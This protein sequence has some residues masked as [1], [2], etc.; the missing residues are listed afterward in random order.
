MFDERTSTLLSRAASFGWPLPSDESPVALFTWLTS[1]GP[2]DPSGVGRYLADIWRDRT[3]LQVAF[4]GV[5]F[6][7]VQRSAFLDWAR[8]FAVAECLAPAS[9]VAAAIGGG[10]EFDPAIHDGKALESTP[11]IRI[12]GYLRAQLGLGAIAR[13]MVSL[14]ARAEPTVQAIPYDHVEGELLISW[15]DVALEDIAALD[16]SIFCV[17]GT[18]LPLLS[19]ALG[20][21]L[22]S[23]SYRI[24]VWFWEVEEL[25]ESMAEGF[26]CL[27]E[28]WVTSTFVADAI[29]N[30]LIAKDL[31][32]PVFVVPIGVELGDHGDHGH[33]GGDQSIG[34][35]DSR[36][37]AEELD[38][39]EGVLV[40]SSFDH[41]SRIERKN[42]IGVI[43]AFCQAFPVP[44][45]LGAALGPW[46]VLKSRGS[47]EFDAA[48]QLV[49]SAINGRP[50]IQVVDTNYS[51]V[52]QHA[53]YR[54]LSAYVSLHRAEG[55]GLGPLEAMA[56][57]VATIAT[58][59]SGNLA[60]MTP[61]NSWLIPAG[62]SV[63]PPN[64]GPYPRGATW[65]EPD[66]HAAAIA[67]REVVVE[68]ASTKVRGVAEQGRADVLSFV[69]GDAVVAWISARMAK[70]R[71][72]ICELTLFGEAGSRG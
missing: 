37:A 43:E 30:S 25:S 63:V 39:P 49:I 44:F 18:E 72:D 52:Q 23:T 12:V 58:N 14:C 62:R 42:P 65:A 40:G 67:I 69:E 59:Y 64:C 47:T 70:I 4:P 27:D 6:D 48:R 56:N 1:S 15:P 13:R 45:E 5:S 3:D 9:I 17:N 31:T 60:F 51:D 28:I 34:G 35:V 16:V 22:R 26:G 33:D 57:A 11:G 36:T 71:A 38:L 8:N 32:I 50:D 2:R 21:Q 54:T 53:F 29:Q 61:E 19:R 41:A 7:P 20:T 10:V 55:Y 46:L 24:G 68:R 66:L